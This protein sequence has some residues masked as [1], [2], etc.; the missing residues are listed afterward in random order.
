[1]KKETNEFG[2]PIG[3]ETEQ[4]N[5]NPENLPAL[6]KPTFAVITCRERDEFVEEFVN[7]YALKELKTKVRVSRKKATVISIQLM[8][9]SQLL[10]TLYCPQFKDYQNGA[11]T[12]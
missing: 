7:F 4:V 10:D 9:G 5:E 11:T 2:F 12:L 6:L 1:M 3:V 8:N